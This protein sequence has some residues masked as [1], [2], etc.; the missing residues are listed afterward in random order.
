M[1]IKKVLI[2]SSVALS[3]LGTAS[4]VFAASPVTTSNSNNVQAADDVS[5]KASFT[6]YIYGQ[7]FDAFPTS[8]TEGNLLWVL[9]QRVD[10]GDGWW[11]A[12]YKATF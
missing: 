11:R 4:P 9:Q 5:A 10:M 7:D 12:E 3:L 2:T 1:S 6:R 8:F